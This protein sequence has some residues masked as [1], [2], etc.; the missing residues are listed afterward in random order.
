MDLED[1]ID[2]DVDLM[3]DNLRDLRD[4]LHDRLGRLDRHARGRRW[5]DDHLAGPALEVEVAR[6]RAFLDLVEADDFSLGH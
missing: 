2:P 3:G 6:F 1:D 5:R 4:D